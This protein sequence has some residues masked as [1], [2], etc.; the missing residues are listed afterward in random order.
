M[1]QLAQVVTTP[2]R[3]MSEENPAVAPQ[4]APEDTSGY[5]LLR[6]ESSDQNHLQIRRST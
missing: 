2:V 5:E 6:S 1:V 3:F 4:V